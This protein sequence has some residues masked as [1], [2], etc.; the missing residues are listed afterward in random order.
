MK[1]TLLQTIEK[2]TVMVLN[3]FF[4]ERWFRLLLKAVKTLR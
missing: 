3:L 1:K 2:L 4:M